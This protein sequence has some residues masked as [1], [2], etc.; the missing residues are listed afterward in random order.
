M[1]P[2]LKKNFSHVVCIEKSKVFPQFLSA[3]TKGISAVFKKREEKT[4]KRIKW[5]DTQKTVNSLEY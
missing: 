1:Q 4:T 5:N 2:V 3:V